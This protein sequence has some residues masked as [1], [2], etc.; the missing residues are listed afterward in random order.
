MSK[1]KKSDFSVSLVDLLKAGSHFGHQVRRW[2]PKMRPFIWK[3]KDNVH[4]FDLAITA[5][6]LNEACQKLS[7]MVKEGGTVVFV[8]TKRQARLVVLEE[9]KRC[10]MPYVVSRW[11][12]GFFTNWNQ[13]KKSTDLLKSLKKDKAEGKLGKYTKKERVLI[14]KKITRLERLFGGLLDLKEYPQAIF[15]VDT[16]KEKTVI[17][18]AKLKGIPVF[19]LLDSNCDPDVVDYPIPANDDALRS[20][21]LIVS[22][23]AD[24]VIDGLGQRKAPVKTE[25]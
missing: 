15:V 18:E 1:T 6:K 21:K 22:K 13:L 8:G 3:S 25:K 12:G 9:A 16:Q 11:P 10:K 23:V 24:A 5:E 19:A 2:N 20:I 7:E 17:K 14:D 4:I